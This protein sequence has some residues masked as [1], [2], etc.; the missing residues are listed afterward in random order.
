MS[1]EHPT[2]STE[3]PM[4]ELASALILD[5]PMIG[6]AGDW[7]GNTEW[8]QQALDLFAATGIT[9]IFHLGD[10]G[11]WP[12]HDGASFVRKVIARLKRHNQTLYV[13]P[14]NHEDYPRIL[15]RPVDVDGTIHYTDPRL[16]LLPRG[17]RG[18]IKGVSF[19]S[20]GG[21]NSIDYKNRREGVSWWPQESI[22]LGDVYRTAAGGAATL[23]FCH[24]APAGV[25][26]GT[27]RKSAES[28][29]DPEE[30]AYSNAG[31]QMLRQAVDAVQPRV[32]FHGHFHCYQDVTAD[33]GIRTAGE[34]DSGYTLRSIGL[35]CDGMSKSLAVFE[36]GSET[37]R[38]LN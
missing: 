3:H 15:A 12:G 33:L 4:P 2:M 1:T 16:K 18:S 37:L 5:T 32:L 38:L 31:R 30:L 7:H 28:G 17:V 35:A 20:L 36:P 24:D 25:P 34:P 21:A 27:L 19:V 13:T 14:G 11:I 29:W 8:A 9:H 26:I 10:F 23:M 6:V 22:T